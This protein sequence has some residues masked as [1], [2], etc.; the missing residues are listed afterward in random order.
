M[1]DGEPPYDV[2]AGASDIFNEVTMRHADDLSPISPGGGEVFVG[3][4]DAELRW[5][6]LDRL[7][8]EGVAFARLIHPGAVIE[9]DVR[10]ASHA[11][12]GFGAHVQRGAELEDGSWMM[13]FS[14]LGHEAVLGRCSTL[15][16]GALVNGRCVI[17]ARVRIGSNAVVLPDVTIGSDCVLDPGVVVT[18]DVPD[19]HDVRSPPSRV[20]AA[21]RD[22]SL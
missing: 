8:G 1:S 12:V 16:V 15:G 2:I 3:I 9:P 14:F 20:I 7:T 11:A 10:L 6:V 4:E 17:G 5:S 21:P 13:P 22:Y 18:S 19:R